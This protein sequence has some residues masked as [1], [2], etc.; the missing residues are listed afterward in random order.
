MLQKLSEQVRNCHERAAEAKRKAEAA[1]D[2]ALKASFLD[3][4]K[5]WLILA[6][7]HTS[8]ESLSEFSAALSNGRANLDERAGT[9]AGA[10]ATLRLQ[11]ISTLLIQEGD[12][13]ALYGRVLNAAII[14]MSAD[15]GSMQKY[16]PEQDQ[17][18]LLVSRG[19][20]PESAAFWEQVNRHSATSC[21]M[22]LSVGRRVIVP[23][24]ECADFMAGSA[25]L[26]VGRGTGIR[27]MHSTPL[28]SRSGR[29]LGM[30]STHWTKP[31]YPTEHEF[32]ALD[33]LARQAADL[34]ER[35][36]VEAALRE[37]EERFRWLASLVES[38]DDAI[39]GKNI[40]GIITSWNK[41]A[42]RLFG[43]TADEMVGK[44]VTTLFPP[45]RHDE[46]HIIL[47]RIMRGERIEHYETVRHRKDG[48]PVD[49]S[50]TVSPVKNA[51]GKIVGASKIARDITE[52]K[53]AEA[54]EKMLMA[55]LDHRVKNV[56]ARVDTVAMSS[57]NGSRSID[58]FA[59]SLKGRIQSMAAA[60]A[61]LSQ[62]GWQGVG[63]EAL[64]R[65]Q[66]A[67]YAADA[68]IAIK[69]TE[70]T[71]TGAAIQAMGMVLHELVT[72]AAKYGALSVPTGRLTV[73]WE[74]R[75]NGHAANLVFAWREFGGPETEVDTKPGYGTRLIRELV[76][77]ELGGAVDL[78]FAAEGLSCRI[79]FPLAEV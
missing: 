12:L 2:P 40:D 66:L 44:P 74:R 77:H 53:R 28:V 48:S 55:E 75:P 11:E 59:R 62:K 3:M 21:G 50:L 32:R 67:P 19:F 47:G 68:N 76:P 34:I 24:I 69:G 8:A 20:R 15:M 9:D 46:E 54:R 14:L 17:L 18:R 1:A 56:L 16:D 61:L 70:V 52:R 79:E 42:Q 4:E 51:E 26:D 7:R 13:D 78:T 39:I 5:E 22:A 36:Q 25:D 63:L 57:R 60:H 6:G 45:D 58:E 72:N 49:V 64:V 10:D 71:L 29:L 33:V 43:Y 41:G 73:S 27:A 31:H 37:S 30:I 35:T 23:D 65:S 38:S